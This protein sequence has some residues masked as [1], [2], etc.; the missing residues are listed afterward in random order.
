MKKLT[1]G[2]IQAYPRNKLESINIIH[3][4]AGVLVEWN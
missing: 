4:S 2:D 3:M 1:E